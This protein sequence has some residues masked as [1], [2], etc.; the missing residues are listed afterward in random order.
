MVCGIE[1]SATAH[2]SDLPPCECAR[3][4]IS[5]LISAT[6]PD[7]PPFLAHSHMLLIF[8]SDIIQTVNTSTDQYAA[9]PAI[10][11]EVVCPASRSAEYRSVAH[12]VR[13]GVFV[14]FLDSRRI[15][16]ALRGSSL[17]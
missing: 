2:S 11:H 5:Y 13:K 9:K 10:G 1:K 6:A 8:I 14:C 7:L 15:E 17:M 12:H 4:F 3:F 16:A